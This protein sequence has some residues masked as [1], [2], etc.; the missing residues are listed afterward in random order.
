MR[1]RRGYALLLALV[2]VS[3]VLSAASALA[4]IVL[5]EIRQTRE[6]IS[7]I[8]AYSEAESIN[9]NALF[10]VRSSESVEEIRDLLPAGVMVEEIQDAQYFSIADSDFVSLSVPFSSGRGIIQP[11][12]IEWTPSAEC[13]AQS[14]IEVTTIAWNQDAS[15]G[16]DPFQIQRYPFS[17][18]SDFET[19]SSSD[20]IQ[21][22]IGIPTEMR[23]RALFCEINRLGVS[24]IPGR[25]RVVSRAT[26]RGVQ[27][28]L[29]TH[30]PQRAPV[31]GL[32]DFVIFSEEEIVKQ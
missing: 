21:F 13:A 22:P 15:A 4:R 16:E 1:D 6:L 20:I 14:W 17:R 23:I 31:S 32:F 12:I 5:S 25:L 29:E 26:E 27:Q 3:A 28:V 11:R 30:I 19:V 7:S 24:G 2:I 9:E 8:Q 10:I 18:A